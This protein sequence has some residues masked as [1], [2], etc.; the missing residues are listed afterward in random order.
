M[1]YPWD[2]FGITNKDLGFPTISDLLRAMTVKSGV[3]LEIQKFAM[4]L[5]PDPVATMANA[6]KTFA[7]MK[8]KVEAGAWDESL[9]PSVVAGL[10]EVKSHFGCWQFWTSILAG[11]EG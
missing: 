11:M 10:A 8:A 4:K 5:G 2:A 6:N 1:K 9:W 3:K 7:E